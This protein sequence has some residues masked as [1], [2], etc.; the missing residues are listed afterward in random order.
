MGTWL[1]PVDCVSNKLHNAQFS[2]CPIELDG[3]RC[4]LKHLGGNCEVR[5]K[6]VS[7]GA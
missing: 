3:L 7:I 5:R 4:A 2:Q 6:R 1:R